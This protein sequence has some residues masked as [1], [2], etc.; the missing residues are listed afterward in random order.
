MANIDIV[1]NLAD[2]SYGIICCT[3]EHTCGEIRDLIYN[4]ENMGEQLWD[5][6]IWMGGKPLRNDLKLSDYDVSSNTKY[7]S[8]EARLYPKCDIHLYIRNLV[9][10]DGLNPYSTIS[11]I[12]DKI[13]KIFPNKVGNILYYRGTRLELNMDLQE[14]QIIPGSTL[15]LKI[16]IN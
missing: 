6:A 5:I 12:Y 15:D 7:I 14:Y 16:Q 4:N 13:H 1:Y 2:I 10:I 11:S 8:I 3:Q 9:D